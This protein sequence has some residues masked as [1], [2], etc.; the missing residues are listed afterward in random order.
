MAK[1]PEA[2]VHLASLKDYVNPVTAD[3]VIYSKESATLELIVKDT[4]KDP[5]DVEGW[6]VLPGTTI[7]VQ[8]GI[9]SYTLTSGCLSKAGKYYVRARLSAS[10]LAA[11][12]LSDLH[13]VIINARTC[14]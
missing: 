14:P 5:Y 9:N 1:T 7:E 2:Y 13:Y 12:A 8:P 4:T 10:F 3:T 11:P 6:E